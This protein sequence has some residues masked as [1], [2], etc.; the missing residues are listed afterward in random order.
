MQAEHKEK[1]ASPPLREKLS[2][3]GLDLS[4]SIVIGSG[5][6]EALGI[7]QSNDIDLV[8]T[9]AVYRRLKGEGVF[10]ETTTRGRRILAGNQYEIGAFW[11]VLGKDR[12]LSELRKRSIVVEGVRYVSLEFLLDVKKSWLL[13]DDVRQKDRDDVHL[14]E[15]YLR[16]QF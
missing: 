12:N 1:D 10:E 8:V 11:Q 16:Q 2:D 3:L 7:R 4:N 9:D 5:I 14:I 6:M 13:D 15:R